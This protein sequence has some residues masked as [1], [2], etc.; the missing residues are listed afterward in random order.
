MTDFVE[1][2][3]EDLWE[4]WDSLFEELPSEKHLKKES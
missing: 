1:E 4:E 2:L 3:T